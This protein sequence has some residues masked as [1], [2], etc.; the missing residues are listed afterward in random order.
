MYIVLFTLATRW[1]W[2]KISDSSDSRSTSTRHRSFTTGGY[3]YLGYCLFNPVWPIRAIWHHGTLSA[4]V[5]VM[6]WRLFGTKPLLEPLLT[7]CHLDPDEQAYWMKILIIFIQLNTVDFLNERKSV[8]KHLFCFLQFIYTKSIWTHRSSSLSQTGGRRSMWNWYRRSIKQRY[9][10]VERNCHA[11]WRTV[12]WGHKDVMP[13]KRFPHFWL[14]AKGIIHRSSVTGGFLSQRAGPWFNI[15]TTSYQY[16]KSHCGDKTV[17]RS[18]Y[19]HNGI[20]YTG[21]I[22]SLYWISPQ[23]MWSSG[24]FYGVV[25][26]NKQWR[27]QSC[28]VTVMN[29]KHWGVHINGRHLTDD[30]FKGL[31]WFKFKKYFGLNFI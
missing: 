2:W 30:R 4:S 24:G 20:S 19:L 21:K 22:S 15:K 27:W 18:S 5:Q 13:W 12:C 10:G 25:L 28:D 6:A 26:L 9:V 16:R 31:S 1:S 3:C 8:H 7:F 17:V 14:F 29:W 23:V 11:I